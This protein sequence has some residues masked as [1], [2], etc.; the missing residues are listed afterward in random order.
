MNP[1][2]FETVTRPWR[3]AKEKLVRGMFDSPPRAPFSVNGRLVFFGFVVF[4]GLGALLAKLYYEQIVRHEYWASRIS[5]GSEVSVRIPAVRGEIRDRNGHVFAE[6]RASYVIEFYLPDIVRS[7]RETHKKVPTLEYLGTVKQMKKALKE[8][9]IVQIVNESVMPRLQELGLAVDY[10]SVNLQRHFRNK[11]EVPY[12][13]RENIDFLTI[14]KYTQTGTGLP[15]VDLVQRPERIYPYGALGAHLFGYVG[16][17]KNL[18]HEVDIDDFTYYD[19]DLEGKAQVERYYDKWLRGTPGARIMQR[20]PKGVIVGE[21][22][23]REPQRGSNVYLTIDI[24][25][26]FIVETAL[27]EAG[28]GRGAVV[29]VDP[30]NGEILALASVPSYDPNLFIPSI[31]SGDWKNLTGDATDPLTDRALQGYAPGSIYKTVTALAG[32][33]AGIPAT[34]AF[35]CSGGVQYGDKYMKCWIAGR[36]A[37]GAITLPD[38]LKNSCNAFFYQWGNAAGINQIDAIGEALGLGKKTGVPLSGESAGVLPGP[39]WLQSNH[40]SE[41]W[42][43]GHTANASIGQGY[44]LAS[45]LQMAMVTATIANRGLAYEPRLVLKVLD[46]DGHDVRDPDTG[47]PVVPHGAKVHADLR[48]AGIDHAQMETVREGMRRVVAEGTGKRGQIPGVNVA[49]KTGTAQFWRGDIPDN[50]AWFTAFAPYEAPRY[51]ICVLVQ[52]AKSGGGVAAPIAQR[53]LE[54]CLELDST[55]QATFAALPPARGSFTPIDK[56]DYNRPP[57]SPGTTAATGPFTSR[58]S[59]VSEMDDPETWESTDAPPRAIPVEPRHLRVPDIR[60]AADPRGRAWDNPGTSPRPFTPDRSDV[61][62]PFFNSP[63]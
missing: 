40:P 35:T 22:E 51:A 10:N 26:Q 60:A 37:H 28:I 12:V 55:P 32:L 23:R 62:K 36:G 57:S 54:R 19:P 38:A 31:A 11:R 3:W 9:D 4:G 24:R 1:S 56:V 7:Y 59:R 15:G 39:N 42:S 8:P 45:P 47:R 16:A 20:N 30:N 14:A 18:E 6:N 21:E 43:D 48:R 29:V 13:Y 53:I 44:V 58:T 17:V 50:H 5:K 41:R 33:R 46:Q 61:L 49:G 27:R 25:V 34:R 63:R 2:L 52:G